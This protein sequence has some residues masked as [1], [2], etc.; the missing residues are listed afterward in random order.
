MPVTELKIPT[1]AVTSLI[2]SKGQ[3]VADITKSSG[4]SVSF[5]TSHADSVRLHNSLH[6]RQ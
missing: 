4:A 1:T 6:T 5:D 2:G 3:K